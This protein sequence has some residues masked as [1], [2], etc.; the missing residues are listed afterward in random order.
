M[1]V[2]DVVVTHA[3]RTVQCKAG[4]ALRDVHAAELGRQVVAELVER[5]DLEPGRVDEVILGCAGNPIDAAN[6]ARV[7]ALRARLPRVIPAVTV[8]RNCGSGME[9]LTAAV[10]RIRSGRARV[11]LAGGVESMSQYP[12]YFRRSAQDLFE[13]LARA[14]SP[15]Q[16][17]QI[18]ARFRPRHFRPR[19]GLRIGLTDPVSGLGMGETAEVLAKEFGISREE[20]DELALM[21]HR[22]YVAAEEAGRWDAERIPVYL[23]PG[24]EE[25]VDE[26]V[27]PRPEQ[28]LEAL[29]KLRPVFDRDYGTVTA[30]NSCM[31]TDGAAALLVMDASLAAEL[32][33]EPLGRVAGYAW[34]GCSPRRMGLGPCYAVPPTLDEAGIDLDEVGLVELNEAFAAQVIACEICFRSTSFARD[35]LG[36]DRSI[37][38]IGRERLNVNG[39]AIALGHP[40]GQTGARLVVT[41]LHEMARRDCRWGLATE[42]IGGGQGGAMVLER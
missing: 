5:A 26:E 15:G 42:C 24:Y 21:S 31:V 10:Q 36:R 29:A 23:P 25:T 30:G 11:V 13:D 7:I 41:L 27:G 17:L 8:Q 34:A 35:E 28:S 2:P 12:L 20:Q 18:L 9:A 32:D 38:E 37:G 1:I 6:V 19:V 22:R 33:Y 4:T 40:V 39:G 3:L 16:R 14:R